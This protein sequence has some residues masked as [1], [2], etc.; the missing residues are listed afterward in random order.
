[1]ALSKKIDV[2]GLI[3]FDSELKTAL[4]KKSPE[5]YSKCKSCKENFSKRINDLTNGYYADCKRELA[6]GYVSI[7]YNPFTCG[8]SPIYI[9]SDDEDPMFQNSIRILEDLRTERGI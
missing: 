9:T 5:G 7:D 8:G 2:E 1:M 3:I 6:F 4:S